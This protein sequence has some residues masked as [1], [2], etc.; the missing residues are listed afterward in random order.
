MITSEPLPLMGVM[1]SARGGCKAEFML[2]GVGEG[3]M[4]P[5]H[6]GLPSSTR[7]CC[8]GD[9]RVALD[10]GMLFAVKVVEPVGF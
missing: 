9:V 1:S 7:D 2:R 6:N 5:A 3:P 4:P 10:V 8:P